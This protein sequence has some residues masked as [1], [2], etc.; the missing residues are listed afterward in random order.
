MSDL[1]NRVHIS[2]EGPREGFQF[3]KGAIP[4]ARK[5]EL[6]DALS[7]RDQSRSRCLVRARE[8]G[9]RHGRRGRSRAGFKRQ[10]DVRL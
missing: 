8:G 9:A 3:E 7:R 2:E 4:T 10:P 6:V 1:P 5:I